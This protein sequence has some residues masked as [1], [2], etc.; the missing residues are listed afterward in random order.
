M[1][2]LELAAQSV[3]G[4]SPSVRVTLKPGYNALTSP[5]E[6]PA[7]V[8]GLVV[9]LA[10][11]DGRGGDG[12]F[13]APG[14]KAGRAGLSIQGNDGSVWRL[15]RD[16]GGSGGL[17][18]L[19]RTSNTFEI[20]TQDAGEMGQTLRGAAGF[21]ARTTWEQL[22]TLHAAQLPTR[23]PKG[24]VKAAASAPGKGAAPKMMSKWG[25]FDGG[26]DGGGGEEVDP[27][28]LPELEKELVTAKRV[29]E[30][31]FRVDAI[32]GE[33]YESESKVKA[34]DALSDEVRSARS[35]A[36]RYDKPELTDEFIAHAQKLPDEKRR[37]DE[38]IA[39][40]QE[41][42][43]VM[44]ESAPAPPDPLQKDQRF[45]GA[46]AAGLALFI[47]AMFGEGAVRYLA[48]LSLV[49]FSFAALLALRFIEDLQRLSRGGG[50]SEVL[51][52]REKKLTDDYVLHQAAVQKVFESIG[53]SNLE[54]FLTA[55]ESRANV[56]ARLGELE[57]REAS[58]REVLQ[59]S[60]VQGKYD[61]LKRE[62]EKLNQ[63]LLGMSGGFMRDVRDIE[64]EIAKIKN[65]VAPKAPK[66]A[67]AA[68][69]FEAVPTEGEKFEDPTPALLLLATDLFSA[70]ITT[71]WAVLKDRAVQYVSALT[72][73]RYHGLS[74]DKDGHLT[75][76][77]P[78]RTLKASDLPGK[79]LD[80]VFLALRLTVIEKA[81]ANSKLPVVIE[82]TFH[83]VFEAPKL[84]LFGRMV[85]HLG[86]LTQVIHVGGAGHTASLA[87]AAVSI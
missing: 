31:Q 46:M 6:L 18:K 42:Q 67:P 68:T 8:S 3:R 87:D 24:P 20:V 66:P 38:Q 14:A 69:E 34:V 45:L 44:A 19:N 84:P 11:P 59:S 58:A 36:T 29:A 39:R 79:D 1:L 77:A 49:P 54:E 30:I 62:Q 7:P 86:S 33:L 10:F 50:K 78:G 12:A 2:F 43:R 48:V 4:F 9:A 55:M 37:V 13:L 81:S 56:K 25:D 41:E 71:L 47:G 27:S 22:F 80:L 85:K 17:H 15:V 74:V 64:R 52:S 73:R 65:P 40:L 63:E 21:P 82:D 61:T 83:Q 5:A 16:L 75:V 28:K 26:G 53:V 72:D 23:R 60:G 32:T 76:E 35:E 57:Q 51:A 70:D